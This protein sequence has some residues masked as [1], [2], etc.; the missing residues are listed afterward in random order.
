VTVVSFEGV[1][2]SYDGLP[3]VQGVNFTIAQREL[4]S[5]VGPNGGGK[6]TLI[7]LML[8]LL[9]PSAGRVT[10][11]GKPPQQVRHRIGYLPQYV[12]YDPQFPVTVR[13]VVLMGRVENHLGGPYSRNDKRV[14]MKVLEQVQLADLAYRRFDALSGGQRQRVLIA[15][16]LASEPELL[17]L[18]EP[19]ANVDVLVEGKLYELL[20]GLKP[21]MTIVV[22]SHDLGF[23]SEIVENVIC[24]NRR[25]QVH[26]TSEIT[27]RVIQQLY[28]E[29]LRMVRHGHRAGGGGHDA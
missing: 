9:S 23:V 26:P 3:V 21:R 15:R 22:V 14:A 28:G 16:A 10:V 5:I 20:R 24:V 25:V 1:D 19:T 11:F 27:G 13:D 2:F 12:H 17:L 8:G 7:K 18:D 6:T 29:E 4:V